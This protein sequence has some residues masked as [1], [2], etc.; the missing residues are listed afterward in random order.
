MIQERLADIVQNFADNRDANY[1]KQLQQYQ[2]DINF[3]NNAQLYNDKPLLEPGEDE[4]EETGVKGIR[5][6]QLNLSNGSARA[7]A[8]PKT[9]KYATTFVQEINDAMEERDVNLTATVVS[10]RIFDH[11]GVSQIVRR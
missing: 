3:I 10:S 2:A 4:G 8:Q 5:P 6:Q 11:A 1:R 7:E 9:G